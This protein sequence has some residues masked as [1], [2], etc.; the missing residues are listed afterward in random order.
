MNSIIYD[1]E[2]FIIP[3]EGITE[4]SYSE[5][6]DMLILCR[7]EDSDANADL[8]GN[9]LKA[10]GKEESKNVDVF[11]MDMD[12]DLHLAKSLDK[13]IKYVI[14]FGLK[15]KNICM[16]AGF[17]ANKLYKTEDFSIMLTHSLSQLQADVKYKK[18]LWG[19]LQ[20]NFVKS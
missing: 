17:R 5:G 1:K 13:Q 3:E 16:N 19:A 4:I 15:P 10:I 20:Q 11:R 8:L 9:I 12:E 7:K 18:A 14:C 6:S 2:I